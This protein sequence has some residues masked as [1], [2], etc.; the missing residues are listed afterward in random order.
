M[1]QRLQQQQ[2]WKVVVRVLIVLL[3]IV[4]MAG[5]VLLGALTQSYGLEPA[6]STSLAAPSS[7]SLA[8]STSLRPDMRPQDR[9]DG[10]S[11]SEYRS[12]TDDI[13]DVQAQFAGLSTSDGRVLFERDAD[14]AVPMASTTK[15]MTAIVALESTPLDTMMKVTLGAANT[16]GTEA[17]LEEGMMVSL[18]DL[19]Y[20]LLVP[21]GNDAA[22]VIAENLS[23][24]ESRFV[25]LMNEKAALLGMSS[26]HYADS[27]GL[28]DED[29]YSTVRDYLKLAQYCMKN[30]VFREV[31]GTRHKELTIDG[32]LFEFE[33]TSQL[34]DVLDGAEVTG[35][36]TGFIEESGYCFVGSA[37]KNGIELY[38]VTFRG[39]DGIERFEDA[40]ELLE[41]G[42]RHY[43]TIELVNP[44]Q[45]VGTVALTS[46]IDKT[47]SAFA[48]SAVRVQVFDLNGPIAQEV[49][50]SDIEGSVVQGQECGSIIWLQRGEVLAT[51]PVVVSESVGAPGFFDGIGIGWSRFWG[52]FFGDAPHA[53]GSIALKS[54]V[55]VPAAAPAT[56][57]DQARAA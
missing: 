30:P 55:E 5:S 10:R 29:H 50:L 22:V 45:L 51:S 17:G 41:W 28:S 14:V 18:H 15:M 40:A 56:L 52:G 47:V 1:Q 3:I 16:P 24:Y 32:V 21:S 42:F 23:G 12:S 25:E 44:Y 27:S 49:S 53:V 19:L 20:C 33:S 31:V 37:V 11:A 39:T 46:W 43:R 38:S 9:I 13:P 8:P 36:K 57:P 2:T 34:W 26:T 4:A 35:I 6:A 7:A 54:V 48:P